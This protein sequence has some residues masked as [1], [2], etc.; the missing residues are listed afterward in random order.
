MAT[1]MQ[2]WN[3]VQNARMQVRVPGDERFG[4]ADFLPAPELTKLA[5][6]LIYEEDQFVFL[7]DWS[8]ALVCLWKRKGGASGGKAILGK[9]QQL[10]GAARHF[11]GKRYL[12]WLGADTCRLARLSEQQLEALVFHELCHLAPGDIDEETG[13]EEPPKVVAHDYEGFLSELARYGAWQRDLVAAKE[14]FDE[15]PLFRALRG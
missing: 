3:E 7:R 9:C 1:I 4:E 11:A 2:E 10:S 12:I 15:L 13:E 14:A 5:H 8:D 6:A